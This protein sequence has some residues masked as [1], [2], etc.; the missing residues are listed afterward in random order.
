MLPYSLAESEA[1]APGMLL[2]EL[3]RRQ[4]DVLAQLDD[5]EAKLNEVLSG[6]KIEPDTTPL[7]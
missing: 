6:L 3:E 1:E 4:D 7:D 2:E 5:L